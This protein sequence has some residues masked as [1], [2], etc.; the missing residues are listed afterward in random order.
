MENQANQHN[1]G[2]KIS[3][4]IQKGITISDDVMHYIDSTFS[5]PSLTEFARILSDP[6]NC[7]TE[8]VFEL[9]FYP[10]L[11]M[12]EKIESILI[13]KT[14]TK[15]DIE[16]AIGYLAQKQIPVP[17][18]FPDQRGT[19]SILLTDAIIRQFIIR[20]NLTKQIDARLVET[21]SRCIADKSE[22]LRIRVMLRNCRTNF[23]DPVIVFL[24]TY[25]KKMYPASAYFWTGLIFLLNFFDYTDSA[26]DMY[27]SLMR[28][29]KML[30][31][32]IEQ[33]EK[34]EQALANNSVES[35]ILKGINILS[36]DIT[37]ARKKI[38]LI[39]HICISIFGKTEL[40]G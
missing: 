32:S 9:I 5:N 36:I 15:T 21:V 19:L 25:I 11:P 39:D 7:D 4:L 24:C 18:V 26:T 3:E 23:P 34:S 14:Y 29:K 20:L 2:H 30:L 1:L 28:E 38:V 37:D 8:P 17:V 33:A 40:Y 35:L 27:A 6:S 13:T 16:S 22:N 31:H 10:D 12:Q